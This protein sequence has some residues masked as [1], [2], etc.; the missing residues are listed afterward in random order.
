MSYRSY[1]DEGLFVNFGDFWRGSAYALR[2]S[3][4]TG[5]GIR[6][7]KGNS[8]VTSR[9]YRRSFETKLTEL[10]QLGEWWHGR[11]D[12]EKRCCKSGDF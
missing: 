2:D 10:T 1:Y 11:L 12:F 5:R 8:G 6:L 3:G 9:I 4:V 7:R